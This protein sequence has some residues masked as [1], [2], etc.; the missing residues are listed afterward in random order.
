MRASSTP[1]DTQDH[2]VTYEYVSFIGILH[3]LP[4]AE[5][6]VFHQILYGEAQ[7]RTSGTIMHQLYFAFFLRSN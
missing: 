6:S 1:T 5:N 2:L 3:D 7:S 4:P